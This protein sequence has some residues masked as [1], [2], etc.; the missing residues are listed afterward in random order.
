MEG[1]AFD[2]ERSIVDL[3]FL[4]VELPS[5][6]IEGRIG[7]LRFMAANLKRQGWILKLFQLLRVFPKKKLIDCK[8]FL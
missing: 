3:T 1:L 5:E 4:N 6:T 8:P 2:G 7:G